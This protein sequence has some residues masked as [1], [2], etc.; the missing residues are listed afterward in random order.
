MGVDEAE[1]I[2]RAEVILQR[3]LAQ[4]ENP[5]PEVSVLHAL[6]LRLW[7]VVRER[8]L[9]PPLAPGEQGQP[10]GMADSVLAPLVARIAG[11]GCEPLVEEAVRQLVKACFYPEFRV[12]RDSFRAASPDGACRRQEL[13]RVRQR[14]SGTHCIDCPHWVALPADV[15]AQFLAQH[16]IAGAESFRAHREVF[17]PEDFRRLR[18]WLYEAAREGC[19]GR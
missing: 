5:V 18:Q 15:H 16:W 8:G 12:C 14:V 7:D 9:L 4:N 6:A 2:R 13:S 11:D 1:F 19:A 10:G 3:F 17:L